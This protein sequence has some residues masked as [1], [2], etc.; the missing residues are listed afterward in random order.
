MVHTSQQLNACCMSHASC[1]CFACACVYLTQ[2]HASHIM[3]LY[4]TGTNLFQKCWCLPALHVM[5]ASCKLVSFNVG[6][7]AIL[8]FNL[9]LYRRVSDVYVHYVLC[10]ATQSLFTLI[11]KAMVVE[12]KNKSRSKQCSGTC[13]CMVPRY[14]CMASMVGPGHIIHSWLVPSVQLYDFIS[15]VC[16]IPF[17][18]A[19]AC[20]PITFV[21]T[22]IFSLNVVRKTHLS[23]V[24]HATHI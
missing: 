11:I 10:L 16:L 14:V 13:S 5:K 4:V 9:R 22:C 7:T 15:I 3:S 6:L 19:H 23:C 12:I 8:D 1:L 17:T 2:I 21:R 24:R 20:T 18:H